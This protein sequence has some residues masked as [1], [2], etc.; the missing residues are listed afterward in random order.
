VRLFYFPRLTAI[1]VDRVTFDRWAKPAQKV[2][3][4]RTA[5]L[6]RDGIQNAQ[7]INDEA[8]D[9]IMPTGG[10]DAELALIR[11]CQAEG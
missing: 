5:Q 7:R 4:R 8:Q 2:S 1:E 11:L 6:I 3:A 9:D 10:R